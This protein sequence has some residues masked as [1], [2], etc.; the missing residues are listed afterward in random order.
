MTYPVFTLNTYDDQVG[1]TIRVYRSDGSYVDQEVTQLDFSRL[2][3]MI[4]TYE[5]KRIH[6]QKR[7]VPVKVSKARKPRATSSS[8]SSTAKVTD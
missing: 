1:A 8:T 4:D 2:P 3:G 5:K 6:N 7:Y